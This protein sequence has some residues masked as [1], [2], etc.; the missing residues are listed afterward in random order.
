M[1]RWF[2]IIAQVVGTGLQLFNAYGAILP[3]KYQLL[4]A[5]ILGAL[6]AV[7]AIV[8]HNYN[9]DGTPATVPYVAPK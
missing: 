5:T 6:Q 8:A 9:P 7:I 1:T 4:G 2:N 3:A